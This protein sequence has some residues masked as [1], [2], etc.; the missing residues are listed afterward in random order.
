MTP[1]RHRL[2]NYRSIPA[3][4]I[5]A[6]NQE[7]FSAVGKGD[8]N[9]RIPNGEMYTDI[10][11]HD[12]L[13]APEMGCTL[14]SIGRIDAAGFS[15]TFAHNCLTIVNLR[16][17]RTIGTV[18]KLRGLYRVEHEPRIYALRVEVL[19]IDELHRRHGHSN[20]ESLRTMVN[21][22]IIKGVK[23]KPG[24]IAT[25]CKPCFLA[26]AKRKP[27]PKIRQR[28]KAQEFADLV[29]S[30][31][32]GPASVR[33]ISHARYF[34]LIVDDATRWLWAELM[35]TKSEAFDHYKHFEAW[36][37]T[38]FKRPIK[39]LQTDRGGEY[40]SSAFTEHCKSRGTVHRL[41]VHDVHELQG[42]V[43]R[44]NYTLLDAVRACLIGSGLP[45]KLWGKA[46][47]YVVYVRNRSPTSALQGK[48]PY[49][50]LWGEPPNISNLREFGCPCFVM[51][52]QSNVR[53]YPP[54]HFLS[55]SLS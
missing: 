29:Y 37:Q 21:K 22:G 54:R 33:T 5:T 45:S 52:K 39:V 32:W 14:I 53:N 31:I 47:E 7:L 17:N 55:F 19:S 23:I 27:I 36:A 41:S 9:I 30:D 4:P 48:T 13:L 44:A 26:K 49:E 15:A 11:L 6:A 42:A 16:T 3:R 51:K 18:D 35:R 40:M 25:P 2:S 28:P 24:S 46:L 10:K 1:Y 43:E 8:M 20:H 12:V 38:Q 34:F 50:A